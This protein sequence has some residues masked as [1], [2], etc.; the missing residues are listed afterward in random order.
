MHEESITIAACLVVGL[1]L[2]SFPRPI[3]TWFCGYMKRLCELPGNRHL[4][5]VCAGAVWVIERI[6]FGRV[7][8]A[9]TAPKA[10]RFAGFLYLCIALENWFVFFGL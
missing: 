8:D 10:F 2:V 5:K 9:A 3:A 7:H 4:A 6:S 1:L